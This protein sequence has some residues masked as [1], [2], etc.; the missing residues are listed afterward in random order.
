[1][2]TMILGLVLFFVAHS[3]K[4]A[5][6]VR[7]SLLERMGEN[8]YKGVYSA[9]SLV[10]LILIGFGF[11]DYQSSGKIL[12]WVPPFWMKHMALLLN[13]IALV[14]FAAA[15]LPCHIRRTLKHPMLAGIIILAATHLL[16]NGDMG[17]MILFGAFLLWAVVVRI[18]VRSR[19]VDGNPPRASMPFDLL[20]LV[21]GSVS[22]AVIV[23]WL[24]PAVF[25]IPVW[26]G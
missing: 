5:R 26:P 25:R 9:V 13:W 21:A 16:T 20:A 1:M 6:K 12:I 14:F 10:G 2:T 3:L 4:V 18:N 23:F 24:H 22:Y 19:P 8:L 7:M 17:G 11:A 15:Y